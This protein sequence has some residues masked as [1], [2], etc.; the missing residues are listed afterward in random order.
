MLLLPDNKYIEMILEHT[1]WGGRYIL[2]KAAQ[3]FL[4]SMAEEERRKY[5]TPQA[6]QTEPHLNY[7][8]GMAG[9]F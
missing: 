5:Y 9:L 2:S 3:E 7:I 4:S 6:W 1:S 8:Y